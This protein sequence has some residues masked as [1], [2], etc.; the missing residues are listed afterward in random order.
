MNT[1]RVETTQ[2]V[3][4]EYNLA[5]L[6]ERIL[7]FLIDLS[8]MFSYIWIYLSLVSMF[9]KKSVSDTEF[10]LIYFFTFILPLSMY[11]LVQ[12][13]FFNGQ[14][15]GKRI[16]HIKVVNCDGRQPS[17]TQYVV[18]WLFRMIDIWATLGILGIIVAATNKYYQRLGD[19]AADTC[20][21]KLKSATQLS[22]QVIIPEFDKLYQPK[23]PQVLL[24][25]D[26]DINYIKEA[27]LSY[28]K[29]GNEEVLVPFV[30]KLKELLNIQ[31]SKSNHHSFLRQIIR[32]YTY[33]TSQE[34]EKV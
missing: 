33:L 7:A 13:V 6:G 8:V 14:T 29:F 2:N 25:S 32:D 3:F 4:L 11:T 16:M 12:E 5:G 27:V 20:L 21:I 24:L 26:T 1:L 15:I 18:R 28:E 23:Y 17:L 34:E 19:L 30:K 9:G 22:Q 10:Y 31:D